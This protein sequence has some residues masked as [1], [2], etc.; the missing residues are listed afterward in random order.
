MYCL[1]ARVAT[2]ICALTA[3]SSSSISSSSLRMTLSVKALTRNR[4]SCSKSDPLFHTL[5]SRWTAISDRKRREISM[6]LN[7]CVT[8]SSDLSGGNLILSH[9]RQYS[10]PAQ[11]YCISMLK[12]VAGSSPQSCNN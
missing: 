7:V 5:G 12:A 6:P 2:A 8:V 10:E 4:G 9:Q 3:A 1:S 11:S